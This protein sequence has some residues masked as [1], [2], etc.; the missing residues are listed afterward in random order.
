MRNYSSKSTVSSV[1]CKKHLTFSQTLLT[2]SQIVKVLNQVNGFLVE[3]RIRITCKRVINS[4]FRRN[5][6]LSLSHRFSVKIPVSATASSEKGFF[7]FT[8]P[9]VATAEQLLVNYTLLIDQ[10]IRLNTTDDLRNS[11]LQKNKSYYAY[12]SSNSLVANDSKGLCYL[13]VTPHR[14]LMYLALSTIA[15]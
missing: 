12:S 5:Y 7:A 10:H 11:F 2:S 3:D 8:R 13:H 1:C 4:A 6:T 14:R 9:Y 15:N